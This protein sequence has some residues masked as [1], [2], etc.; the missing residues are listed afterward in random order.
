MQFLDIPIATQNKFFSKIY[1]DSS[2]HMIKQLEK[3]LDPS[4]IATLA[5]NQNGIYQWK[6]IVRESLRYSNLIQMEGNTGTV[7]GT[8][9][10]SDQLLGLNFH[11]EKPWFSQSQFV[12]G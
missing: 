7:C 2:D 10:E 5:C 11:Y 12:S 1:K 9:S 4:P 8:R 3:A 6:H